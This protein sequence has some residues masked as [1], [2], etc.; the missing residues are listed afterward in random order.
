MPP[1]ALKWRDCQA[2]ADVS[3]GELLC[4]S[5]RGSRSNPGP[6]HGGGLTNT[7]ADT[8]KTLWMEVKKNNSQACSD[9]PD[10]QA[11]RRGNV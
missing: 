9:V 2:E 7:R 3:P 11:G 6:W 4:T 1:H 8:A 10:L 5:G